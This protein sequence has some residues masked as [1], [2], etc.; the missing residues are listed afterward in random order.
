M[1]VVRII[2][3]VVLWLLVL[4]FVFL[5]VKRLFGM[6]YGVRWRSMEDARLS[7]CRAFMPVPG[8]LQTVQRAEF[9]GA[10]LA[11]QAF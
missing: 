11:L 4:V 6:L 9:V 2:L 8:P 10:I 7:R 5:P 3:L 1:V